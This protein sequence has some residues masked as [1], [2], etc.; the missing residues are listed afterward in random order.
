L[1]GAWGVDLPR[2]KP[3][4]LPTTKTWKRFTNNNFGTSVKGEL[5][6]LLG[7]IK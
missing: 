1:L 2:L 3:A 6:K 7:K 4:V 5:V